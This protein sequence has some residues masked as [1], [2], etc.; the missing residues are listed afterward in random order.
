[1]QQ[2]LDD[3]GPGGTGALALQLLQELEEEQ[4]LALM[5]DVFGNYGG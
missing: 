4:L 2:L 5:V 1:M 3:A